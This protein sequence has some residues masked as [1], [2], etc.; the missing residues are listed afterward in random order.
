[1]LVLHAA[2]LRRPSLC[3]RDGAV[4]WP[5]TCPHNVTPFWKESAV[6]AANHAGELRRLRQ[7]FAAVGATG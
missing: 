5:P 4:C 2:A 1:M 6:S 3:I 7:V